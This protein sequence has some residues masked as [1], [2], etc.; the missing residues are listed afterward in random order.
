MKRNE[1][2]MRSLMIQIEESDPQAN[3]KFFSVEGSKYTYEEIQ[4]HLHLMLEEQL[5][6]GIKRSIVD[7]SSIVDVFGLTP[8]GHDYLDALVRKPKVDDEKKKWW[9][10]NPLFDFFI[11]VIK[12]LFGG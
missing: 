2:L 11:A 3:S 7:G 12:K 9:N 1:K 10:N 5:I 6:S 4:Y 8:K